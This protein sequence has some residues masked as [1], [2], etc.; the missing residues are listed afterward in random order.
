MLAGLM[1]GEP[2]TQEFLLVLK[3]EVF[4]VNSPLQPLFPPYILIP[5]EKTLLNIH[6]YLFS[7]SPSPFHYSP[8]KSC[9]TS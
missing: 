5:V 6:F 8:V 4:Q 3:H 1:I 7:S 9:P 2:C